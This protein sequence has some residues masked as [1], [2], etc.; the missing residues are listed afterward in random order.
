MQ[1]PERHKYFEE[2]SSLRGQRVAG[3]SL[4][5]TLIQLQP[6]AHTSRTKRNNG[7]DG[8][9]GTHG[10]FGLVDTPQAPPTSVCSV[11]SVCS[12]VSLLLSRWSGIG[13]FACHAL[14]SIGKRGS[15]PGFNFLC[16]S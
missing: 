7:T 2:L 14:H 8:I 4:R 5:G 15:K 1:Q 16:I 6:A 10:R 13:H 3:R 9:N 12:V 11:Y